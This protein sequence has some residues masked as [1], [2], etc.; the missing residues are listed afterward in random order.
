MSGRR[1]ARVKWPM[2]AVKGERVLPLSVSGMR[3]VEIDVR[4]GVRIA[5]VNI[6]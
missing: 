6:G 2:E 3:T 4:R 1:L 5:L